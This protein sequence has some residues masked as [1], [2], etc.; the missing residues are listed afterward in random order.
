MSIS[1]FGF[2]FAIFRPARC[3]AWAAIVLA[4]PALAA[5]PVADLE[6][7]YQSALAVLNKPPITGILIAEVQPESAAAAAGMRAGDILTE[8]DGIHVTTLQALTEQVSETVALRIKEDAAGK[9]VLARV[10]RGNQEVSLQLHREVLGVRAL[11]VQA[12]V[13]GPRNPPPNPRGTL[14]L[15]WKSLVQTLRTDR[16][17]DPAAFRLFDRTDATAQEDWIGWELCTLAPTGD[18]ALAGAIDIHHLLPASPEPANVSQVP[19][20][21]SAF[22]FRLQLGDFKTAPAFVLEEAT[23]RYAGAAGQENAKIFASTKRLGEKL[24]T[25]IALATGDNVPDASAGEHHENAAPLNAIPQAALP[26]IA[27]AM[28]HGQ[29]D[30]LALNL[31][32]IRDFLPRP[33][34]VLAT[35]GKQPLPPEPGPELTAAMALIPSPPE[36]APAAAGWRVDLMHCG[37]IVES[38]WCT[39][40]RRVLCVQTQGPQSLIARR[41]ESAEIAAK[42]LERTAAPPKN[43]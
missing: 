2:R 34:Y 37:V 39:D 31:L 33:G 5:D 21:R 14:D 30:A 4:L 41:V 38:Y 9:A 35:R 13:P 1:L 40:Q 17:S 12:G 18:N 23:E 42:P 26:W 27:A 3:A 11:E 22:T 43:N 6:A 10:R 28:P 19:T 20:E 15:D 25:T 32:S 7:Q 24:Q 36:T 8:Y 29:G 16:L